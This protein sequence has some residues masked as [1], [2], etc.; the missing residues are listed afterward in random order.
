MELHNLPI[1]IL[2][3]VPPIE[4]YLTYFP[5]KTIISWLNLFSQRQLFC[6]LASRGVGIYRRNKGALY[7]M[8]APGHYLLVTTETGRL[9]L[10]E[11]TELDNVFRG[12]TFINFGPPVG[13]RYFKKYLIFEFRCVGNLVLE[14]IALFLF[15]HIL[16][17]DKCAINRT[18]IPFMAYMWNSVIP[19]HLKVSYLTLLEADKDFLYL[20]FN[21]ILRSNSALEKL[22]FDLR[23][24]FFRQTKSIQVTMTIKKY[25]RFV[26]HM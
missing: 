19:K 13:N 9:T 15:L 20:F 2:T 23:Y 11:K 5:R 21:S 22:K 6:L 17:G 4:I 10:A 7:V 18:C 16:S 24:R 26:R 25:M 8:K 1:E 12:V 14:N 3:R